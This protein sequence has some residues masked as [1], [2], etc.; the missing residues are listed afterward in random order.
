MCVVCELVLTILNA[1]ET[2]QLRR[3]ATREKDHQLSP[4]PVTYALSQSFSHTSYDVGHVSSSH[5]APYVPVNK[6][7][8]QN[9]EIIISILL[10]LMSFIHQPLTRS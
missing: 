6:L 8:F 3:K 10:G 1:E 2:T 5:I 7:F 9:A 4:E